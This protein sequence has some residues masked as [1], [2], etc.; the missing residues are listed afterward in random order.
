MRLSLMMAAGAAALLAGPALAQAPAQ[1]TTTATL[2]EACASEGRDVAGATATGYCRGFM[3]GAGQY[4]REI[5]V[6]RPPIFCL[7]DPSPS[8][9]AAQASFVAWARSNPQYGAEPAV[10][11]L[12]RWAATTYPCPAQPTPAGRASRTSRR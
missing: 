12:M 11:G 7:P 5:S 10:D 1:G 2:A 8:F 3:T 4:H 9:D 6:S